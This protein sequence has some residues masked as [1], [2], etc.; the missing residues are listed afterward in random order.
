MLLNP[1]KRMPRL[2][3]WV[4]AVLSVCVVA[5][6]A[7]AS[8][9][10]LFQ[11]GQY[12]GAGLHSMPNGYR[13]ASPH[14]LAI[15]DFDGNGLPDIA[16]GGYAPDILLLTHETFPSIPQ[17]FPTVLQSGSPSST[18]V[19]DVATGDL[20]QDGR[21]D[22]IW[23]TEETNSFVR[24]VVVRLQTSTGLGPA[25]TY[26][27]D[28]AVRVAA[29]DVNGDGRPDVVL[30]A[31]TGAE[32]VGVKVMLS[33]P[34]GSLGTPATYPGVISGDVDLPKAVVLADATGDGIADVVLSMLV[35]TGTSFEN[36]LVILQGDGV[37]G[38]PT[39]LPRIPTETI[40]PS[41]AVGQLNGDGIPDIAVVAGNLNHVSVYFGTGGGAFQAPVH[42]TVP[43]TPGSVSAGD[44]DG[45]GDKDL[46]AVTSDPV[47]VLSSVGILRNNG[48]GTFAPA[49]LY[50]G[51]PGAGEAVLADMN[52]DGWLDLVA[53]I[54]GGP[55]TPFG[56]TATDL[57]TH[58]VGI[59][60]N[61]GVGGFR[62]SVAGPSFVSPQ[63]EAIADFNRDGLPDLAIADASSVS[64]ALGQGNGTFATPAL[65][66]TAPGGSVIQG[67][68]AGDLD[69]NGTLDM[70]IGG[71]SSPTSALV[72]AAGG[73]FF[74][75]SCG[76]NGRPVAIYDGDRDG[77]PDI[78]TS[79]GSSVTFHRCTSLIATVYAAGTAVTA[80][81]GVNAAAIGDWN[82]D[83]I[84]DVV[85]VGNGGIG[86]FQG[87]LSGA[88]GAQSLVMGG[89]VYNA[90]CAADFNEDGILDL[91]A[92]ENIAGVPNVFQS[93]GVDVFS[94]VGDGTFTLARSVSTLECRGGSIASA[95][96]N[97]D[98]EPD[99]I[100]AGVTDAINNL[101]PVSSFDLLLNGGDGQFGASVS[102]ALGNVPASAP[103]IRQ[104]VFGDVDHNGV[105]DVI[106]PVQS[107][108]S[109]F[110][111]HS[112]LATPP[113][114]SSTLRQAMR[115]ST[116]TGP[117]SVALGDLNR[118]GRLDVVV[119]ALNTDPGVA[120]LLG[121]SNSALGT[122]TALSQAGGA[123]TVKLAD[124][125]RDGILDIVTSKADFATARVSTMIGAGNG[126]FGA[127][128]DFF[129][130]ASNNDF[131][132][133]DMN[134][135]GFLDVVFSAH[136]SIRVLLSP[137]PG[138]TFVAG[139]SVSLAGAT[140]SDIDLT[141]L[142]RDG[143]LDVV[144][145]AGTVKVLYGTSSGTLMSPVTLTAPLTICQTLAVADI[146]RDGFPDIV[147]SNSTTYY[148]IWGAAA[149]PF[150]TWATATLPFGAL[151][152]QVGEAAADG[153]PY[154]YLTRNADGLEVYSVSPTGVLTSA[155]S[156]SF[157]VPTP[158]QVALGDLDRDGMLDVV[159]PGSG[160]SQIA[161]LLHGI[162]IFTAVD[163][164]PAAAPRVGL[165]Q[166]YPNPFNP[167]TT[168]RYTLS[169][170]ERVQLRVF[171]VRGRLVTTLRDGSD[172][173]GERRVEWD[174]R[175][176]TGQPVASGVYL[177]RLTTE[178]GE[179]QSRRM[180]ILK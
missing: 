7:T 75:R 14:S 15:A 74:V 94:G 48:N 172:P 165:R 92:R 125:N 128:Y 57:R 107:G 99:L 105:P 110:A 56:G 127:R 6:P 166:N 112:V 45:D 118:D 37:G 122:S 29:G 160:T 154:L 115:Y 126:T 44:V 10:P 72:G 89:R 39:V 54:L 176:R 150:T 123:G 131:E 50:G 102:Y 19:R 78:L 84:V 130:G 21:P 85:T 144:V 164:P 67:L 113:T 87:Q 135:D 51:L 132:I 88:L 36:S 146:N 106:A 100:V 133:G 79:S 58:A 76:F 71:D 33:N 177:Y 96:V 134:R 119:G 95:D 149:S 70:V 170:A 30:G 129:L 97:L 22:L 117:G 155:A 66:A 40:S 64:L 31:F 1:S 80:T 52:L 46:V 145:A 167:R 60:W 3:L 179:A 142:N 159:I 151:D 82:R 18:L 143:I 162:S 5:Q 11:G 41:I 139:A 68:V 163:T 124:L 43:I 109:T 23:C 77:S 173:A 9:D 108:P 28:G 59:L 91:A 174:G 152:L 47:N 90:V 16:V 168:I 63:T 103:Y 116:V 104:F 169:R 138:G 27:V 24:S 121:T 38:F 32:Q 20:N 161:V 62:G 17:M 137:A 73:T 153:K 141:D 83:G 81:T 49:V 140:I 114:K 158:N 157:V 171:D 35:D 12:F 120:V 25:T 98:G 147:A 61:D 136:D 101:G 178:S 180:L 93:R 13:Y 69:R 4:A 86:T 175:D 2:Y 148:F 65:V 53:A 42:H 111:Y 26:V 156:Q 34:D 8:W 55:T